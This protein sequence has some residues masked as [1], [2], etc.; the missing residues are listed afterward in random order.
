MASKLDDEDQLILRMSFEDNV[1]VADM[2][3]ILGVDQRRL[4]TVRGRILR[5]LRQSLEEM[6]FARRDVAEVFDGP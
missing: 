5:G 2:S 4:Y 6:G 3:R 1:T